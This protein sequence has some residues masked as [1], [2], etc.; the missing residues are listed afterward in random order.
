MT[1]PVWRSALAARPSRF[2]V[3]V[4]LLALAA[5]VVVG[6][7]A[8]PDANWD[9]G[10]FSVLL[11]FSVLSDLTAADTSSNVKISGQLPLAGAGDGVPGRRARCA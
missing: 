11:V 7:L 6:V 4:E 8:G 3:A 1:G 10:L 9:L 2:V 5:A